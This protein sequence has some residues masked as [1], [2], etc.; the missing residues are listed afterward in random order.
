MSAQITKTIPHE[1][2]IN[3]AGSD[4]AELFW[5][6]DERD[7]A[8]FFNRLA[9]KDRLVLQLQAVTNSNNLTFDGRM[10][11]SQIGEYSSAN[12]IIEPT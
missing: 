11:M 8:E 12:S 9:E 7:Q 1:V 2:E 4:V 10:A 6:M 3:L 5:D